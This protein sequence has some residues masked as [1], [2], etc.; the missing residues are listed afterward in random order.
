MSI[1]KG[2]KHEVEWKWY[3]N[4]PFIP[5]L[6]SWSV[7]YWPIFSGWK[8]KK[9]NVA[10]KYTTKPHCTLL[11]GKKKNQLVPHN[12]NTD[13]RER[14]RGISLIGTWP[15]CSQ[16][17]S[18]M[19]TTPINLR[20]QRWSSVCRR[21]WSAWVLGGTAGAACCLR[22]ELLQ[23]SES[24]HLD[25]TQ[26]GNCTVMSTHPTSKPFGHFWALIPHSFQWDRKVSE[27]HQPPP[28]ED[29]AVR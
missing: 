16:Q 12:R 20:L 14:E 7:S 23:T 18:Q 29:L 10:A 28:F 5:Q 25:V 15:N 8:R 3:C 4:V 17:A 26:R 1:L 19:L 6:A 27:S 21:G 11:R 9:R 24:W 13:P 2:R 22:C